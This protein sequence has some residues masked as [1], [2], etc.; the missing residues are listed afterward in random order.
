MVNG[1]MKVL[2]QSNNDVLWYNEAMVQS[3]DTCLPDM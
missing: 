2:F 1:H 3:L